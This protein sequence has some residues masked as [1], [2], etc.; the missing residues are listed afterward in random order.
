M[1]TRTLLLLAVAV[2]VVPVWLAG[3]AEGGRPSVRVP[4][5]PI[6]GDPGSPAAQALTVLRRWDVRR[7][8]AW[9]AGDPAALARLYVHRSQTGARDVGDLLRWVRRGLRVVGLH[10][11]VTAVRVTGG[12]PRRIV[13]VVTERTV[14][15]IAVGAR[16]RTAVPASAWA[17]HRVSLRLSQGRWRVAEV[18]TQPA[19]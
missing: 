3:V 11:Q 17:T 1:R 16:R 8:A 4:S 13:M 14:D 6:A 5:V 7:A 19:R 9:S 18:R 10:Q 12:D 2:T 15:G